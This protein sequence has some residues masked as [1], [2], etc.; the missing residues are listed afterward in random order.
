[1]GNNVSRANYF[2][3]SSNLSKYR[4]A[5]VLLVLIATYLSDD[6]DWPD[7]RPGYVDFAVWSPRF[8]HSLGIP[9]R[10]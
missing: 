10:C 1:L 4:E 2:E 6:L 9:Q 7:H 8:Q 3:I 5:K